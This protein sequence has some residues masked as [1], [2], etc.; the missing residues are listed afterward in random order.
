MPGKLNNKN[1]LKHGLCS[2]GTLP[3]HMSYV[4]R[5]AVGLR[6]G[7]EKQCVEVHGGVSMTQACHIATA[8]KFE[9]HSQLCARWLRVGYDELSLEQRVSLS[10]EVATAS[11]QR[12]KSVE[13][14]KLRDRPQRVVDKLYEG[15]GT[16]EIIQK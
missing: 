7:L 14:L 2:T 4:K 12:D 13:K 9:T 6:C 16:E 5:L 3:K 1:A 11:Q 8:V 10:R 15:I